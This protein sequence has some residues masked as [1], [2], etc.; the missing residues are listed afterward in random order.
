MG[1]KSARSKEPP[2]STHKLAETVISKV[3]ELTGIS[4]DIAAKKGFSSEDLVLVTIKFTVKPPVILVQ[5]IRRYK[6]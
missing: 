4:K 2:E 5:K 6:Q 3:K 1:E